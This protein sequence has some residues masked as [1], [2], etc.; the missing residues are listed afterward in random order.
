MDKKQT[1]TPESE[2]LRLHFLVLRAQVGDEAAFGQLY[3]S[4]VERTLRFLMSFVP[5]H[6]AEDLNQELWL[7]VY[8][9]ISSLVNV[10]GFKTWLFQ[11]ARNRALDELRNRKRTDLLYELISTEVE[12]VQESGFE[13]FKLSEPGFQLQ[14]ALD[15]LSGPHRESI[16]LNFMEGMDYQEIALISACSVGTVKSRIHNAKKHLKDIYKSK[17]QNHE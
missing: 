3:H 8:R 12:T 1:H 11:A 9:R 10:D 6:E 16:V 17:I 7:T 5:Q 13:P 4:Y 15:Q 14:Q 2:K